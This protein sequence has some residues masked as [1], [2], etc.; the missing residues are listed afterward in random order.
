MSK[1]RILIVD[2]EEG[3]LEGCADTLRALPDVEI[4]AERD[5]RRAAER[6]RGE[7]FDLLLA[8]VRMPGLGG[9]DLLRLGREKD[10]GLM[11]LMLTAFP[12]VETAVE[13][14]KLGASDY[15]TKPFLP[16][17]LLATARRLLEEKRLREENRLLQRQVERAYSFGEIIGRSAAMQAVYQTIRSL[18]ETDAD[19]L[20]LGETGTGKELVARAIHRESRRKAGRFVPVDC[21]AIPEDLLESEFFGHERG[22]FTGAVAR[23]L[24][25]LEFASRGTFFLDEI[26]ELPVHLQAKLLRV[27]QERKIRRVGGTEEI[28]VDV[29]VVAA[30]SRNLEQEVAEHRFRLDLYYRV[31][32]GRVE[33]PPLRQRAEDIPLLIGHF[34][35]RYAKEMGKESVTV[36]AEAVEVLQ[37]Y[38]WPGNVRELQN[39]IKRTL[40]MTRRDVILPEDLPEQIV[41]GPARGSA[42]DAASSPAAPSPAAAEGFFGQREQHMSAFE[43]QYLTNLLRACKGDTSLGAREAKLPRG[44]LYRLLKKYDLNPA[45]FRG[46]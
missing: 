24:G 34:T 5:S 31:H 28:D 41:S 19:V 38:A 30:T 46:A 15:I 40:A 3:M 32:V 20:I 37:A 22:A 11:V 25:L 26:G 9:V 44:T 43:R 33:L 18:A 45:D 39:V 21:G 17:D 10:P 14:M 13:S 35:E 4:V 23:S 8:D 1:Q 7:S 29:R 6:L 42:L 36:D 2:D 27:L 16:E 12:T